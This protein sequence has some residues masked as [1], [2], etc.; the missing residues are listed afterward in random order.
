M[1]ASK[2]G[3]GHS[4]SGRQSHADRLVQGR[5]VEGAN[6]V[7]A[8]GTPMRRGVAALYDVSQAIRGMAS[9]EVARLS[10]ARVAG[11]CAQK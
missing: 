1:Q 6:L 4:P 7:K 5:P 2:T 9:V 11:K 8:W 3:G 10:H